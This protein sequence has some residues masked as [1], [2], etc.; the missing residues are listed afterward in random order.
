[1]TVSCF[2]KFRYESFIAIHKALHIN[3]ITQRKDEKIPLKN[4]IA[5]KKN[6]N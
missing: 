3:K 6:I 5:M 2:Q 4:L 1:M